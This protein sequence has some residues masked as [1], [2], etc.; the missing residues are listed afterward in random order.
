MT[1]PYW[2][3]SNIKTAAIVRSKK[4]TY[5]DDYAYLN[6]YYEDPL[7][8]N[9]SNRAELEGELKGVFGES[10]VLID[11]LDAKANSLSNEL[12]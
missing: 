1:G 6:A 11:T 4:Y 10:N 8:L 7:E 9:A 12:I 3:A 5:V 2:E